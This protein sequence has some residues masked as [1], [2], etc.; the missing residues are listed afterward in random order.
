MQISSLTISCGMLNLP[1]MQVHPSEGIPRVFHSAA[2]NTGG[3]LM[4]LLFLFLKSTALSR[5]AL[6]PAWAYFHKQV[7]PFLSVFV[8]KNSACAIPQLTE[9]PSGL[10]QAQPELGM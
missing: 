9:N 3:E 1:V 4:K 10:G 5:L 2:W 7:T 8:Q 6:P